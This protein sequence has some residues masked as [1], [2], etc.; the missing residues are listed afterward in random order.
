MKKN[1]VKPELYYES[2]ELSQHIAG[3][4]LTYNNDAQDANNCTASGTITIENNDFPIYNN[5]WFISG[6]NSCTVPLENY[7]YTPG[8]LAVA[9][10]NS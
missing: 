7:C 1:Y 9:S 4:N 3:C 5:S 2:F 8:S 6:N 10:F